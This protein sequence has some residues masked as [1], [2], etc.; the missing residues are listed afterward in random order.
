MSF[1]KKRRRHL[2]QGAAK[3]LKNRDNIKVSLVVQ[4]MVVGVV[5]GAVVSAYRLLITATQD[6]M[7]GL[8]GNFHGKSLITLIALV[9]ASAFLVGFMVK[10]E[11]NISGSGIPQV[12]AQVSGRIK[13][14]DFRTPLYKFLGGIISMGNG[15]TLGREG[16]CVQIGAAIGGEVSKVFRRPNSESKFVIT[17]GAAAGLAAAF[18]APIAGVIFA[19]EELHKNFSKL[20]LL[21]AMVASFAGNFVEANVFGVEPVLSFSKVPVVPLYSYWMLIP[22]G[23]L[24]GCSG[25]LFCKGVMAFK[26]IYDMIKMPIQVKVAL[27]FVVTFLICLS[28][29]KFFGSGEELIY[30]VTGRNPGIWE[31]VLLYAVKMVLLFI[32]FGSGAPGGIFL[33]MLAMGSL[34]GSLYVQ[35]GEAAGAIDINLTVTICLLAMAGHFSAIVKAPVTGIILVSEMSGTFDFLLPLGIVCLISAM[36]ASV[37]KTEPIYESL[38]ETLKNVDKNEGNWVPVRQRILRE[39]AVEIG[40]DADGKIVAEI[41]WPE[42]FLLVAVKRGSLELI[43]HGNVMLRGGDYIVALQER[44]SLYNN[45]REVRHIVK[46]RK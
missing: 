27:P 13:D 12:S 20:A 32:A 28:S 26:K 17:A 38:Q 43:P 24:V 30:Y 16:P 25:V 35:I 22:L 14:G 33:P 41:N 40:S 4:S 11:P 37:L 46:N 15:L 44:S 3:E 31:V 5:S 7:K 42:D 18:N 45:V 39:Y 10:R 2:H 36:T 1:T 34:L 29:M 23:I 9:A 8:Y 19:L 6:A 21:S